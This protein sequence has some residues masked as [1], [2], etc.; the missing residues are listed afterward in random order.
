MSDKAD[1]SKE[2]TRTFA[3]AY[4]T[5]INIKHTVTGRFPSQP[6]IQELTNPNRKRYGDPLVE[7][8]SG[9]YAKLGALAVDKLGSREAPLTATQIKQAEIELARMIQQ[10]I[11]EENTNG[12]FEGLVGDSEEPTSRSDD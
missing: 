10:H 2:Q 9:D 3:L 6:E 1:R 11:D 7:T 8:F 12:F 5:S 4:G